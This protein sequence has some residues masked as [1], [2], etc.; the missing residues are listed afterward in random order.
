[1][2]L[3]FSLCHIHLRSVGKDSILLNLSWI[4]LR[5]P[6]TLLLELLK[7]KGEGANNLVAATRFHFSLYQL[8]GG[9]SKETEVLG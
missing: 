7:S 1:M 2:K 3:F 5:L 8:P 6:M 9:L 4:T